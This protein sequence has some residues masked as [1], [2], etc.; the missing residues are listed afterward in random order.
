MRIL[1]TGG[2]GYIGSAVLDALTG[3]GHDVVAVVRTADAAA[4]VS[5]RGATAL[6]GEVTDATWFASALEGVDAAIHTAAPAD[7]ADEFNAAVI[8]T[9]IRS[10]TGTGRR[11]VLTSGVWLYGAG[12]DIR[13]DDATD[14]GELVAWRVPQEERLL[15]SGLDATIVV[16]GVVYGHDAGLLGLITDGPRAA[17][18]ALT[19]IGGGE[20][21]WTWVHVDDLARL[22]L[23]AVEHPEPLG[24]LIGSDGNPT[25]VRA[26]AESV[27]G[28]A[29][30]VAETADDARAR[31]GA[32]FADAIL[33]D[34]QA[35][36]E[37]AR[38]LGWVPE[39]TSVL[40]EVHA[41]REAA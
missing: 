18:G 38:L 33:L 9:V 32:A 1:L 3:A 41:A 12:G 37:R 30:V 15:A 11:F 13:D 6:E 22:Y 21:H 26:V 31:F 40:D 39:H 7:G 35:R 34:Q 20:Q 29:G 27:A 14:A 24:R 17:N 2:T 36:G 5:A 10:F 19:L 25:T 23:L 4:K 16:P 28:P 8:E